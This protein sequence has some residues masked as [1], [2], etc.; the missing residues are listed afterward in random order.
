MMDRHPCSPRKRI[1]HVIILDSSQLMKNLRYPVVEGINDFIVHLRLL[2]RRHMPAQ[3]HYLSLFMYGGRSIQVILDRKPVMEVD[4]L[5]V[6]SYRPRGRSPFH[7]AVGLSFCYTMVHTARQDGTVVNAYVITAGDDD[8]STLYY[9]LRLKRFVADLQQKGWYLMLLTACKELMDAGE[10]MGF[11][12]TAFFST[13][14]DGIRALFQE[15]LK[16][17]DEHCSHV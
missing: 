15:L 13:D 4:A 14:P 5:V 8:S 6:E 3:D 17:T 7:D 10:T 16:E 9:P 12:G 2:E 1:Y 11:D